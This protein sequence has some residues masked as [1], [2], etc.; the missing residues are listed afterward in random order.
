[1]LKPSS[2]YPNPLK[3]VVLVSTKVVVEVVVAV[4]IYI[5]EGREIEI[6]IYQIIRRILGVSSL[7]P[8]VSSLQVHIVVKSGLVSVSCQFGQFGLIN[9]SIQLI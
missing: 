4:S 5:D 6:D 8:P 1:M 9:Y 2:R 3:P 7:Q